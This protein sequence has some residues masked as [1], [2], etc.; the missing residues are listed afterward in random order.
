MADSHGV[1]CKLL[2]SCKV[3]FPV[4]LGLWNL[5]MVYIDFI[6]YSWVKISGMG[7]T[8]NALNCSREDRQSR[9]S[10]LLQETVKWLWGK[11]KW[12]APGLALESE[13]TISS[14]FSKLVP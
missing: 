10:D 7:N 12:A 13:R 5:I 2:K 14:Q 9:V 4:A 3:W 8:V 1:I 11:K 6:K